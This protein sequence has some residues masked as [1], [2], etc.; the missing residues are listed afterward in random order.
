MAELGMLE[1]TTPGPRFTELTT[2]TPAASPTFNVWFAL[3]MQPDNVGIHYLVQIVS[4]VDFGTLC[5][6][7]VVWI[8]FRLIIGIVLP[9][10]A[11]LSPL[12]L[13]LG[14]K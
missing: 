7:K 13:F 6:H 12:L 11:P 3:L 5:I 2:A 1:N 10:C 14:S 9:L 4:A 8:L